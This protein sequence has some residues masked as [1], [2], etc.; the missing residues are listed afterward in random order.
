MLARR[1]R[2]RPGATV[3]HRRQRLEVVQHVA[4]DPRRR[5]EASPAEHHAV[6]GR[7]HLPIGEVAFEPRDDEVQ[8]CL[9]VDRVALAPF[10][11]VQRLAGRVVDDEMRIAVHTVD[12]AAAEQG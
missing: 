9:V 10:M 2:C 5:L 8:R 6:A 7:D 1:A 11:S 4:L 3:P 12:P